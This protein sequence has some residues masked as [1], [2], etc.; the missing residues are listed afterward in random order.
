MRRRYLVLI[1]CCFT[2]SSCVKK[3]NHFVANLFEEYEITYFGDSI[4]MKKIDLRKHKIEVSNYIKKNS[5]YYIIHK[6]DTILNLST[7]NDTVVYFDFDF[8]KYMVRIE[9][10]T[11]TLY[12]S[13]NYYIDNKYGN[14]LLST[15]YYNDNYEIVKFEKLL[16]V[17]FL[18][19]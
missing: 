9:K 2:I 5:E 6:E 8:N 1:C 3:H 15:L 18:P 19:E 12:K 17:D 4:N 14:T 13:S 11:P 10:I 16:N 7:I